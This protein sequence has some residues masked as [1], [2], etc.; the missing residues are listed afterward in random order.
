MKNRPERAASAG[1]RGGFVRCLDGLDT[2]RYCQSG[3]E[4]VRQS[5]QR[6]DVDAVE[7]ATADHGHL[8]GGG[9]EQAD[10]V[11]TGP[12]TDLHAEGDLVDVAQMHEQLIVVPHQNETGVRVRFAG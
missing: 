11:Q 9:C 6:T 12:D 10:V 5:V 1:L 3:V 4:C 8:S 7:A 2:M